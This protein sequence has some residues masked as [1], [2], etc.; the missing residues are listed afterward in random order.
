MEQTKIMKDC[1]VEVSSEEEGFEDAWFRAILEEAPT[2]SA[3]K[4]LRV[5]YLTLLHDDGSS[6]LVEHIEERFIRPVPPDDGVVIEEGLVVDAD[7][8]D[9]WWTGVVIKKMEDD[10]YLV[11]FGSPPD[12]LRFERKQLRAHLNWTDSIWVRPD[13]KVRGSM[14]VTVSQILLLSCKRLKLFLDLLCVYG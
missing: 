3:C 5:R 11:Y 1:E 14:F 13:I 8:K 10:N 9:G 12:I 6:P 4:K 7:H 2:N